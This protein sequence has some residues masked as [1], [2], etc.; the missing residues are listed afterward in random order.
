MNKAAF[1]M[2]GFVLMMIS[3]G[4]YGPSLVD[5]FRMITNGLYGPSLVDLFLAI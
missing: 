2:N 4:L 1:N 3:H 5:L